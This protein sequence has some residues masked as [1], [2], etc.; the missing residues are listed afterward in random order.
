[1]RGERYAARLRGDKWYTTGKPCK[2]GHLCDRLVID[3]SCR[4]CSR[5]KCE[6]KYKSNTEY[7]VK[8]Y[9][10]LKVE[11]PEKLRDGWR[12]NYNPKHARNWRRRNPIKRSEYQMRRHT[13]KLKRDI[14]RDCPNTQREILKFYEEARR[15]T[16]ETGVRHEVDHIIPLQAKT[17]SGLHVPA[18]L[19]I[20]T[21]SENARKGNRRIG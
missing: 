19:Q 3:G 18:N 2:H 13:A 6:A 7:W 1:M 14:L 4:E 21:K 5:L 9:A 15:L 10:R 17:V 12:R 16:Q 20:L 11:Q 8:R